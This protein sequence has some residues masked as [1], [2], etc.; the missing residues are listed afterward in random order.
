ME[1]EQEQITERRSRYQLS[2][3]EAALVSGRSVQTIRRMVKFGQLRARRKRTPQGFQYMIDREHLLTFTRALAREIPEETEETETVRMRDVQEISPEQETAQKM[4]KETFSLV[5][6]PETGKTR[7]T[8]A[9]PMQAE[10]D[11][12]LSLHQTI[13][14][15]LEHQARERQQFL[16]LFKN[17]QERITFLEEQAR[18]FQQKKKRWY[19]FF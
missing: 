15:L 7:K 17:L 18:T 16:D 8:T 3:H 12:L 2:L 9:T 10:R 6:Q 19:E 5:Q 1:Q 13:R 11:L 14:D 4:N